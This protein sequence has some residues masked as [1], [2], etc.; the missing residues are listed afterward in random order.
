MSNN[1]IFI[2]LRNEY[3]NTNIIKIYSTFKL[4]TDKAIEKMKNNTHSIWYEVE[5]W[6]INGEQIKETVFSVY[7]TLQEELKICRG[8][9]NG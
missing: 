1:H 6:I 8:T 2:V 4:A 5:E 7:K 3:E 9:K